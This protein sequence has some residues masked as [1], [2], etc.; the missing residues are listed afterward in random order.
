MFATLSAGEGRGKNFKQESKSLTKYGTH[1]PCKGNTK[2]LS[3]Q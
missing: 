3:G 2:F 1:K